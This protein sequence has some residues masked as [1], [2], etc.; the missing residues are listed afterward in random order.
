VYSSAV[1]T[2]GQPLCTQILSGQGRPPAA[3]FGVRKLRDTGLP[4]GEDRIPLC[5]LVLTQYQ[6]VTD[7]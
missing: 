3:I 4:Y 5:S 1:F 2:G 6:S 7:R